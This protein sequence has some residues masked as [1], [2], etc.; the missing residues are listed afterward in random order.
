MEGSFIFK[1]VRTLLDA[2]RGSFWS[3]PWC[4]G[5]DDFPICSIRVNLGKGWCGSLF[6]Q[7]F[8][9]SSRT[10]Q[11][12]A[13]QSSCSF[14][15]IDGNDIRVFDCQYSYDRYLYYSSYEENGLYIRESWCGR[16]SIEYKRSV[17]SSSHGCC[18]IFDD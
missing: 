6:Y 9:S 18:S 5:F 1:G 10:L 4:F 2:N 11:R 8:F 13:S 15:S 14:I 16:S 17:N 12:G 7:N 3:S